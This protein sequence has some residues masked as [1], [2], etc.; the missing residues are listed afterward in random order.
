[1]D[2]LKID[3]GAF[4]GCSEVTNLNLF[5]NRLSSVSADAFITLSDVENI[6][7]GYNMLTTLPENVFSSQQN[8]LTLYL[9]N[10]P[11]Q[12]IP[13]DVFRPLQNLRT[14]DL[15][16]A[17]IDEI[18][19]QWFTSSVNLY[20]LYLSNNRIT[21][22]AN[23]FV[24]LGGLNVLSL[25]FNGISEFPVG[26][27]NGLPNLQSLYLY[28]NN[29]GNLE[30]DSF[31]EL[32][33]LTQLDISENPIEAIED[34]AFRGLQNLTSLYMAFC[35]L[36]QLNSNSFE[37]L[38]N[39]NFIDLEFNNI[40]ELPHGVFMPMQNLNYVGLFNNR[41]KTVRRNSFGSLTGLQTLDMEA[42]IINALDSE[43]FDD[44]VNLNTLFFRRNL[45]A[46]ATF[47]NFVIGREQLLPVLERCFDNFR[48]IVD[49]ITEGDEEFLFFEGV[50]P[51]IALRV[52]TDTE[53]HI[54]L[55]PF[56]F[57]WNPIIEILIGTTNNTRSVIRVNQET[58]VVTVPT[59]NILARNQWNDFRVT[60]DNQVILVFRGNNTFPFM[61]YTMQDFYPVNFYGLRAVETSASW[62]VQPFDW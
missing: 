4:A 46:D 34:G 13:A 8:L 29:I 31:P 28:G 39:V 49:T 17:N 15:I 16:N 27:W 52:N 35:G 41:L 37:D 51:G 55:T 60:W 11:F 3:D 1:V 24:G 6:N 18:N 9:G 48:F 45:C 59:P 23:S 62:T 2:L 22:S 44:A 25:A 54:A 57:V 5:S 53:A 38:E 7:L 36:R 20:E 30:E 43:I 50:N 19:I 40:E 56:N 12:N 32:G 26:A 61:A 42:N 47:G 21:L 33:Q 14:L 58:D 10:N